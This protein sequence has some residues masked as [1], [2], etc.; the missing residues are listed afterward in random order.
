VS[1]LTFGAGAAF[2]AVWMVSAA[3]FAAVANGIAL[4]D[5]AVSDADLVRVLPPM[6]RLLLPSGVASLEFWSS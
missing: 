3:T 4:R 1:K 6:G 5:A 2:A